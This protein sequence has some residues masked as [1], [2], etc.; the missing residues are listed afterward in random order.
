MTSQMVIEGQRNT[1]SGNTRHCKYRGTHGPGTRDTT[2]DR[3]TMEQRDRGTNGKR[4]RG[5]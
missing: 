2:L 3:G 4:D 1:G 5:T